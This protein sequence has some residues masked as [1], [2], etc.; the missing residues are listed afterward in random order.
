MT[1]EEKA[2]RYD[3]ALEIARKINSGEGVA[4]SSGWTTCEVIF[5]ELRESDD[6][7]IRKVLINYFNRYK[8]QDTIGIET[9]NGIPTDNILAW[10]EKQG[11]HSNFLDKIQIGDKVTR[12]EDGML[13]NLSQL[14]RVA[15]P[16]DKVKPKFKVGDWILIDNPCQIESIDHNGNYIVRYC[17]AEETHLLSSKFCDSHFHLWSIKDAKDGDVLAYSDS[18]NNVYLCIYREYKNERVYDYCTLDKESFWEHGNW[19]YLTSFNYTPTTKKQRDT[20]L[21]L[22]VYAG[23]TFDFEKKE[24]KKIERKLADKPKFKVK[25]AGSEYNV[26]KIK[27]IA[28]ITFYGIEDEPNHIDY[29][30]PDNCEIVSGYS[31]NENGFSFPTKPIM[32]S[33]QKPVWSEEEERCLY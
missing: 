33:E 24:L 9:F 28:G 26:F 2:K 6:E 27:D 5:P 15:K 29:V 31:I 8:E 30:L 3:K 18:R 7:K 12:N 14:K 19:N 32:F 11:G 1:Q 17:N 20:L 13:V 10:L 25:Y 4:A 21:K 16:A 22:M 23:Y